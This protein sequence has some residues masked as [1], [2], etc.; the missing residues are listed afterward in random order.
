MGTQ[1]WV[2]ITILFTEALIVFKFDWAVV[3]IPPPT[4]II[5]CWSVG[6]CVGIAW[7]IWN[8]FLKPHLNRHLEKKRNPEKKSQ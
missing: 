1:T 6:A 8:F 7:I 3:T 5:V 4:H 2:A